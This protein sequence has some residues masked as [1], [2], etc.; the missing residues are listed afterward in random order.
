[1]KTIVNFIGLLAIIATIGFVGMGSNV[2]K[3][4]PN[5][6]EW[7]VDTLTASDSLYFSIPQTI[8]NKT[9]YMFQIT[10]N[11]LS[12]ATGG[13]AYLQESAWEPANRWVNIDTVSLSGSGNYKFEGTTNARRLQIFIESDTTTQSGQVFVASQLVEEF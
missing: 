3:A 10:T 13:N 9:G 4:R 7:L 8:K 6:Y 5:Q 2:T 11:Q 1:M 12:G